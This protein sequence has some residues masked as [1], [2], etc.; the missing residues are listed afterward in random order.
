MT[1]YFAYGSNMLTARLRA[2]VPSAHPVGRARLDNHALAWHMAGPDGSAKCDI[3]TTPGTVVHGVLFR[4]DAGELPLLD[5]AEGLG[6]GYDR[7]TV[8]VT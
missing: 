1:P 7:E 2:R 4:L 6:H 5:A 8:T 3:V